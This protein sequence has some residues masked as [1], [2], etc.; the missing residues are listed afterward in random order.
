MLHGDTQKRE[1]EREIFLIEECQLI[2][3][4]GMIGLENDHFATCDV[5][6]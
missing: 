3:I 2:N 5:I 6:I 1:G 4:E